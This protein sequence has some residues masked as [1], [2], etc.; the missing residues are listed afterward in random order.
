MTISNGNR[1]AQTWIF[2][3]ARG[4]G[5]HA[6]AAAAREAR[7]V[8]GRRT[9]ARAP[10]PRP[11]GTLLVGVTDADGDFVSYTVDVQSITLHR[12]NG[13]SVE[14]LPKNTRI[15]F[16][17]L[18]D[19]SDLLSAATLA[20][21]TS[22]AP[23]SASTTAMRRFSSNR[24]AN[25]PGRRSSD[26]DGQPLGVTDV[27]VQFS[28]RDHLVVTRGRTAFLSLDF[29]LAASNDVDVTQSP[30]VVTAR[31]FIVADVAPVAEKVMRLRGALVDVDAARSSYT[32]DLRPWHSS[33]GNH[34]P[35]HGA[36]Y[37]RDDLRDQRDAAHAAR[38]PEALAAMPA[39]TLTVAFGTLDVAD[40]RV[41][42]R[43]RGGRRQ[44]QRRALRRGARQRRLAR[45]RSS[46]RSRAPSPLH[47]DRR[48]ARSAAP[49][50]SPS[51]PTR[52]CCKAGS[53]DELDSS[54]I[55]VDKTSSPSALSATPSDRRPDACR[56][57]T[58]RPVAFVRPTP[59]R[60]GQQHRGRAS[61]ISPCGRSIGS[62][63]R[64]ST[65]P[66]PA[67]RS[68]RCGSEPLRDHDR[69][70]AQGASRHGRGRESARLRDAVRCR[71]ARLRRAARSSIARDLPAV[72]GIGWGAAG[73]GA[74]SSAWTRPG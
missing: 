22:S 50:S 49:C 45:R 51:A 15:D 36:H 63:A 17:Q 32:V 54:A 8:T 37:R 55:S 67:Q 34:R 72:L 19:L 66:A 61:S 33:A 74:P 30:P 26:E 43:Y 14:M 40:S 62:A 27:E 18:T 69:H 73:T 28:D 9:T 7:H 16:A 46:S 59:A 71:A 35:R 13:A 6:L 47:H 42:C 23:L 12:A 31:P 10:T 24:R 48:R 52:R 70:A 65:S 60:H 56:R 58:R 4:S 41:H 20:P 25:R 44:R 5:A 1:A 3:A 64:C 53:P 2:A 39:G 38:R 11:C 29:D 21:G 68:R 57:S